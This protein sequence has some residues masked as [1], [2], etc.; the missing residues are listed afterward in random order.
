MNKRPIR[1]IRIPKKY[2]TKAECIPNEGYIIPRLKE[3]QKDIQAIGFP[4]TK[5]I[6]DEEE[7]PLILTVKR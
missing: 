3:K 2:W 1:N 6:Y 4:L 5:Q 7:L